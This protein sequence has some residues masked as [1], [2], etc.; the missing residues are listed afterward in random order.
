MFKYTSFYKIVLQIASGF[1]KYAMIAYTFLPKEEEEEVFVFLFDWSFSSNSR[2]GHSYGDVK[3]T[4]ESLQI[5]IH[6][7]QYSIYKLPKMVRSREPFPK[8][9]KTK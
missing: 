3:I 2:I 9:E 6:T 8:I 7:R 4:S 5:L 1:Y